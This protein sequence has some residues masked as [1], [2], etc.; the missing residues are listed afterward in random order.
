M[1]DNKLTPLQREFLYAFFALDSR[2]FLTGGAALVGFVT[3]HRTTYDL[4]L[5]TTDDILSEG[6]AAL[7]RAA[8]NVG[9]TTANVQTSPDFLRRLV[10]RDAES[11][12][13]DLVRDRAPQS[14]H[15]KV[16]IDSIS[17]DSPAE[18]LAN[19][20]CALLSRT[21]MR[22]LVDVK[23]LLETGLDLGQAVDLAS[24]KDG[25]FSPA[26]LGYVLHSFP[27]TP[28]SRIPGGI[29]APELTR[30]RDKIA[31]DLAILAIP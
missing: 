12:V 13:V 29:D 25:G 11:V 27:V 5:F 9:A 31:N 14:T 28:E 26:T 8:A 4:D 19:K 18:I 15:G 21:E 6:D 3:G 30:F 17:M 16:C 24:R 22:D 20:L 10:T 7:R 23:V 2:F 1:I